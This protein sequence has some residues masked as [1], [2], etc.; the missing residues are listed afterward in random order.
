MTRQERAAYRLS[1]RLVQVLID[2]E[3]YQDDVADV[4]DPAKDTISV[5]L[6]VSAPGAKGAYESFC[7]LANYY[8]E[9]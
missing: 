6:R 8:L 3:L 5:K 1:Q 4:L 2:I 7:A 9:P